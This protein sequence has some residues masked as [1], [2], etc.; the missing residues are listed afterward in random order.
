M[1]YSLLIIIDR[2]Y[3]FFWHKTITYDL[4]TMH[5]YDYSV[6][7]H[8]YQFNIGLLIGIHTLIQPHRN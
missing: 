8:V 5:Y 2:L 1:W 3:Y 6:Y 7:T 4:I